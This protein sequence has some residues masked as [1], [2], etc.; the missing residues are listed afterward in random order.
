MFV[1]TSSMIT[2]GDGACTIT[3]H[4]GK[5]YPAIVFQQDTV[6][7]IS[8]LIPFIEGEYFIAE[9]GDRDLDEVTIHQFDKTIY[10]GAKQRYTYPKG[11][12]RDHEPGWVIFDGTLN[13]H[14][15]GG[16]IVNGE[17]VASLVVGVHKGNT[18]QF[19][20][21]RS[22]VVTM[23]LDNCAEKLNES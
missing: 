23:F 6:Y 22:S 2:T 1:L 17:T 14:C 4:D 11:A 8:V 19:I 16:P 10:T 5:D 3:T 9:V 7:G 12:S 20:G 18:D 13:R 15:T 21:I